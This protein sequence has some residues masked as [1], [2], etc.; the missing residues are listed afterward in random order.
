[1]TN[2]EHLALL[3]A[4]VDV[5]PLLLLE[6]TLFA[7]M[8]NRLKSTISFDAFKSLVR[9]MI[10]KRRVQMV[11]TEDGNKYK[12]TDEGKARWLELR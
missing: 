12:I 8:N 11:S 10:E 2:N 4:L 5:D 7:D 1:M 3:E 6:R 9:T